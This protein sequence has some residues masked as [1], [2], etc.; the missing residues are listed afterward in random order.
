MWFKRALTGRCTILPSYG[1]AGGTIPSKSSSS[2]KLHKYPV[3]RGCVVSLADCSRPS[4][5]SAVAKALRV[6][7]SVA[8]F[9]PIL[10]A[11]DVTSSLSAV[12]SRVSR[13][14]VS[15]SCTKRLRS[16]A[17][18]L[19]VFVYCGPARQGKTSY[20]GI[21]FKEPRSS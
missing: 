18:C 21:R 4:F 16:S 3:K 15:V 8:L 9:D 12:T 10:A 6:S 1:R 20:H 5:R 17:F 14:L 11:N 2:I 13:A 7:S 19:F